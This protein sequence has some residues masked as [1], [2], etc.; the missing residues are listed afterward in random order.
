MSEERFRVIFDA[1]QH[2][3]VLMMDANGIFAG[4]M[5][6]SERVLGYSD[7][8]IRGKPFSTIFPDNAKDQADK[9]L[10]EAR[11]KGKAVDERWHVRKD[12]TRFWGSGHLSPIQGPDGQVTGFVKVFEDKTQLKQTLETLERSNHELEQFAYAASHD[13]KEPLATVSMYLGLIL[14]RYEKQ[15]TPEMAEWLATAA[16]SATRAMTMIE[17]LLEYARAEGKA[18]FQA[19]DMEALL[20][21]TLENLRRAIEES[22][23]KITHEPLPTVTADSFYMMQVL[24]NLIANAIK[25]RDENRA[26]EIHIGVEKKENEWHFCIRDNGIGIDP[27][28]TGLVFNLFARIASSSGRS[29]SGLGLA[30]CK[31]VIDLHGGRIWVKSQPGDGAT[32]NFTLPDRRSSE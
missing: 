15:L 17:K 18:S 21:R 30:L 13:L 19:I 5:A 7:E 26:P 16:D 8:D 2:H 9:E 22:R 3:A 1:M 23:A 4:C 29:G 11:E 27:S 24:Q 31:K 10:R 28:Q 14:S 12:G 25:Y 20:K 6:G 32:F